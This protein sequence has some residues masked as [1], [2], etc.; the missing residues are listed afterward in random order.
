MSTGGVFNF[1]A[2]RS[3]Y[4]I[5][6]CYGCFTFLAFKDISGGG[7]TQVHDSDCEFVGRAGVFDCECPCRLSAEYLKR[8]I[9]SL[10]AIFMQAGRGESWDIRLQSGNPA[11]APQVSDYTVS[12]QEEQAEAHVVKKTGKSFVP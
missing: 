11:A 3:R 6:Q 1:F 7:K 2:G 5:L 8:I 10:K 4:L 12:V 9:T